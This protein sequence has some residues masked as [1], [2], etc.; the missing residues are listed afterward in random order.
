M[1]IWFFFP[2]HACFLW[3]WGGVGEMG[4]REWAQ[5]EMKEGNGFWVIN[6]AKVSPGLPYGAEVL[7]YL[8][9]LSISHCVFP[10]SLAAR[11]SHPFGKLNFI[12]SWSWFHF[13]LPMEA[14]D[15]KISDLS[16]LLNHFQTRFWRSLS[17]F[18]RE[19]PKCEA[20]KAAQTQ[21]KAFKSKVIRYPCDL[22]KAEIKTQAKR[23]KQTGRNEM[24]PRN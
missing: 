14:K 19:V 9:C 7:L 6:K 10:A 24:L 22:D 2:T 4:L 11:W 23:H 17:S 8:W 21:W 18:S 1:H 3:L 20:L 13:P 12:E 5:Q 16:Q 15:G